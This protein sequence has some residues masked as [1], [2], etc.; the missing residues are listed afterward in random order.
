[1]IA[2]FNSVENRRECND[3]ALAI[4]IIGTTIVC[5]S[6]KLN[7][8]YDISQCWRRLSV[9][10]VSLAPERVMRWGDSVT[11][12]FAQAY[13]TKK[14]NDFFSHFVRLCREK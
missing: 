3:R 13:E 11:V 12:E 14:I 7:Y 8:N 5:R 9:R 4:R 1:M 10:C 2:S 6:A